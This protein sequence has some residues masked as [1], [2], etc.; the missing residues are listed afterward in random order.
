MWFVELAGG[1]DGQQTD[2]N[3]VGRITMLGQITEFQIPSREGS[4]TN[5]AVGP[6]RNIWYTKGGAL[7]RVTSDGTITEFPIGADARAVGLTAGSDRRPP[8][9]LSNRLWFADGAGNKISYLSFE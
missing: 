4:P 7:G 2:G 3:R 5:I 1:A 9:R 6:D 8:E